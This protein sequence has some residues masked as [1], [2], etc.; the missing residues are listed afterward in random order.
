MKKRNLLGIIEDAQFI[1]VSESKDG[2]KR[3]DVVW[4]RADKI[5]KNGRL[6]PKSVLE[7][8]IK[9]INPMV[10]EKKILGASYHPRTPNVDDISHRWDSVWMEDDGTCRGQITILPTEKGKNV[11]ELLKHATLGISSRGHGTTTKKTRSVAGKEESYEEV[12]ADF[13]LQS[14]G[15]IVISPSTPGTEVSLSEQVKLLEESVNEGFTKKHRIKQPDQVKHWYGE[16]VLAG[17][18]GNFQ[19]WRQNILP[20]L[21]EENDKQRERIRE[22][23]DQKLERFKQNGLSRERSLYHEATVAGYKGTFD[24]WKATILPLLSERKKDEER[25]KKLM[26]YEEARASG[27]TKSFAEWEKEILPLLN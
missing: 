22:Q 21:L 27:Y 2:T 25:T 12:N 15:D 17:Y 23:A 5:N 16:A 20:I 18:E 11:L 19:D 26:L 9:Q 13:K 3:L 1:P 4:Q 8:A 14:P 7:A 24:R 10:G 6:Y